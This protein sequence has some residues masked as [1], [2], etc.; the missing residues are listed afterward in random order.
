MLELLN[1]TVDAIVSCGLN[2]FLIK[3]DWLKELLLRKE[4]KRC[5]LCKFYKRIA[6]LG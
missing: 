6:N 5:G 2:N 4:G 3:S 1:W